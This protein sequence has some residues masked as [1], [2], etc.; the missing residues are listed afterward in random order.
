MIL[1]G[2]LLFL[3]IYNIPIIPINT[4]HIL[5]ISS[6]IYII[7]LH[8]NNIKEIIKYFKN[9]KINILLI[10][11][12]ISIAYVFLLNGFNKF[13]YAYIIVLENIPI[14]CALYFYIKEKNIN[15]EKIIDIFIIIGTVQSVLSIFAYFSET[16]QN[17][18]VNALIFNNITDRVI[19]EMI[20]PFRLYGYSS[21]LTFSTPI[22]QTIIAFISLQMFINNKERKYILPI[23]LLIF[24][25]IINARIT[26]VIMVLGMISIFVANINKK[27]WK[28]LCL[29]VAIIFLVICALISVLLKIQTDNPTVTWIVTAIEEIIAFFNGEKIGYFDIVFNQFVEPPKGIDFIIGTGENLL[30]ISSDVGFINDLYMGGIILCILLYPGYI[31]MALSIKVENENMTKLLRILGVL[32]IVV[33]NIKWCATQPN[34]VLNIYML[35]YIISNLKENEKNL[36]LQEDINLKIEIKKILIKIKEILNRLKQKV[37]H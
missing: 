2:V 27:N 26:I 3:Y 35:L 28:K 7:K 23:P 33:M 13:I 37:I 36:E 30:G 19:A 32:S 5:A 34:N 22:V 6:I 21:N 1:L 31:Y 12:I 8:R 25:A 17:I 11:I 14:I 10:S 29:I 4:T 9:I 18:F 16:I 24:S 15:M 20:A